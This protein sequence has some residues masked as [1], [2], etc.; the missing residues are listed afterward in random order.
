LKNG[1][2]GQVLIFH[3]TSCVLEHAVMMLKNRDRLVYY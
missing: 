2:I 1:S 3:P